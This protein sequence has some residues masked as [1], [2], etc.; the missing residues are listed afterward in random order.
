MNEIIQRLIKLNKT[1][2]CMESCTG[3]YICN[4]ITNVSGSSFIFKFGALTY[5]N[6]YKIKMG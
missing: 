6:L 3:G 2:S 4:E 5:S 1:V